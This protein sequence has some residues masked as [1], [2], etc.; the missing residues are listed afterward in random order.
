MFT[1]SLLKLFGSVAARLGA[2]LAMAVTP[3]FLINSPVAAAEPRP[4]PAVAPY[5]LPYSILE[6]PAEMDAGDAMGY[7]LWS[8]ESGLHLRTTTRGLPHVFSG[9]IRTR[10]SAQFLDVSVVRLED[11][12]R[13][14]DREV[15]VDN[16]A[17]RFRFVTYDGIDGMDFRLDGEGFCVE[18]ENNG[19]EAARITRLGAAEVRPLT[20]PVCFKR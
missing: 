20:T 19:H 3:L 1:Q 9:V 16:D 7:W 6:G 13:N 8:D 12:A 18:L 14:H 10:E 17:I 2:A 4:L 5:V 11:R 15:Q